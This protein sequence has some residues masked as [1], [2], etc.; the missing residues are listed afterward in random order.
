MRLLH[1]ADWHIGRVTMGIARDEDIHAAIEEVIQIARDERPDLIVHA[2]DVFDSFRPAWADLHWATDKLRELAELAPTV[3]LAGNHDS[4]ALFDL[5]QKLLGPASRLRFVAKALPPSR[6]GVLEFPGHGDE[7]VRL[8]PIPFIHANR[9]IEQMEDPSTWMTSYADRVDLIQSALGR[10]LLEGYDQKRHV[11]LLAAH[12][13]VTGASFSQND[14]PLHVTDTYAT[15]YE[16]IPPVSYAAY[17]HIHRPQV[18]RGPVA[19]RFAGSAVQLDFGEVGEEKGV[20]IVDAAPGRPPEVSIRRLSAGRPLK[21]IQG[22]LP[23]IEALAPA[24]GRS[25]CQVVVRTEVPTPDLSERLAAMMPG[26]ILDVREDCAA[27]RVR[28]LTADHV[29]TDREP[30][31]GELFTE[32]VRGRGTRAGS[33]DRVVDTFVRLL[34]GVEQAEEVSF[35][36][37]ESLEAPLVESAR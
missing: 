21:R 30:S 18:L 8:A 22:T 4:Q 14:R 37:V 5:L 6:G 34:S 13:H 24:V 31:L 1:T 9:M 15:H 16:R 11:L 20:V 2:G 10:G 23:E 12:L 28:V 7:V 36:E 27:T 35:P 3:V 26:A 17:G 29:S 19:G 33:A 32:Y 25:I